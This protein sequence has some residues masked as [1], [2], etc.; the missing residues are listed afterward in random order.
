MG[1]FRPSADI[2]Y[3]GTIAGYSPLYIGQAAANYNTSN[4]SNSSSPRTPTML[5]IS[6]TTNDDGSVNIK[7]AWT[8]AASP[9]VPAANI[10]GFIVWMYDDTAAGSYTIT[11]TGSN[12]TGF[13]VTKGSRTYETKGTVSNRYYTFAVQSYRRVSNSV[14]S[15]GILYSN[16]SQQTPVLV[17]PAAFSNFKGYI[18]GVSPEFITLAATNFNQN[19]DQNSLTP[20]A[21]VSGTTSVISHEN[22]STDIK[23]PWTYTNTS[24]GTAGNIDGF[25]VWVYDSLSSGAYTLT[26]SGSDETAYV[27]K[28]GSRQFI[29]KGVVPTRYY[30][31]GVQAYRKVDSNI[32][33]DGIL[34]SSISQQATFRPAA[35]SN[36]TGNL[37]GTLTSTVVNAAN[38]GKNAF[39]ATVQFRQTGAP[40]GS[41]SS[42]NVSP[43]MSA[44]TGNRRI[45]IQWAYSPG[46]IKA[47]KL[48]GLLAEGTVAAT[49]ANANKIVEL[50]PTV[51]KYTWTGLSMDLPY[52]LSIAAARRDGTDAV[53]IS[54]P[55]NF[56]NV[57]AGTTKIP[58]DVLYT[59]NGNSQVAPSAS[60]TTAAGVQFGPN[61]IKIFDGS[62][63]KRVH[64][65][66]LSQ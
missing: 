42:L 55:V 57:S 18:N 19:N 1:N 35:T 12:E 20:T 64:I 31:L 59:S 4:D 17:R 15:S 39:D 2:D 22:S 3:K 11:G 51:T 29:L 7:V 50:P 60:G 40:S 13:V 27:V 5:A 49:V 65:G 53:S 9:D 32:A 16:I 41:F 10:D 56:S 58:A 14:N 26:G 54:T 45:E 37:N 24:P 21:P 30:T 63:I 61:C 46:A 33:P 28:K 34:Y 47:Q 38:D 44:K 8:F 48:Y 62:G 43:T 52:T 66:D 25:I 6:P 36:F 23:L